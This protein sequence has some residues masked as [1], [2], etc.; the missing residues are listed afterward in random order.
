MDINTEQKKLFAELGEIRNSLNIEYKDF[1]DLDT[2]Q[3]IDRQNEM[4]SR[5]IQLIQTKED[6]VFLQ[7][8]LRRLKDWLKHTFEDSKE[9]SEQFTNR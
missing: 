5:R 1:F 3:S 7:T 9:S 4:T 2:I 8:R 6:V